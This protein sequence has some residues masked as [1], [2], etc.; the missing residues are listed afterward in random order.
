[1]AIVLY[2]AIPI[3]FVVL[4]MLVALTV[5]TPTRRWVAGF[6]IFLAGLVACLWIG[7]GITNGL[8]DAYVIMFAAVPTLALIIAVV[9]YAIG[10]A[11]WNGK[12]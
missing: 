5:L 7:L 11:W 4:A 9:L 6:V 3:A 8:A 1:M 10:L 2:S 12:S